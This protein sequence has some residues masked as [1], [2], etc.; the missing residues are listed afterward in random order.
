MLSPIIPFPPSKTIWP[1]AN[2]LVVNEVTR[3]GEFYIDLRKFWRKR[4]LRSFPRN[5]TVAII[6]QV[7][8]KSFACCIAWWGGYY[9]SF[10]W[11]FFE[12]LKCVSW[13][14]KIHFHFK[15][16]SSFRYNPSYNIWCWFGLSLL[17]CFRFDVFEDVVVFYFEKNFNRTLIFSQ[18]S[19]YI[20]LIQE[21]RQITSI[22]M[23]WIN[24][25]QK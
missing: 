6:F 24:S 20:C 16:F 12:Q 14:I 11:I 7:I 4:Q 3:W 9:Y 21:P 17:I 25:Y 19:C 1:C 5:M 13:Q 2:I 18:N 22:A 8:V 10:R 23:N 15:K